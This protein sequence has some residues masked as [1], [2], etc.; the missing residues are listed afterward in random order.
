MGRRAS[1]FVG[2][3]G[4]EGVGH[5]NVT[6]LIDVVMCLIIFYLIVGRLASGQGRPIDLP[7]T[8]V[9][10]T[11]TPPKLVVSV[12]APA[13]G[14]VEPEVTLGGSPVTVAEL[15]GLVKAVHQ[16]TPE[17]TALDVL[18]PTAAAQTAALL[19]PRW[20]SGELP[21]QHLDTTMP[22]TPI[23]TQPADAKAGNR[24]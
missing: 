9:G 20:M 7:S 12:A 23:V 21:R 1:R 14:A 6:P 5:I 24:R 8:G 13:A 19:V 15:P 2:R 17:G 11:G 18:S 10:Q 22:I 3:H 16:N 4:A